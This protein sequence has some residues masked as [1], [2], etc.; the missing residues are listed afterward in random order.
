M[1]SESIEADNSPT[2]VA[3]HEAGH[4]IMAWLY[5]VPFESASID[6]DDPTFHGHVRG[7]A[8]LAPCPLDF[9]IRDTS[10]R[11]RIA[12][13]LMGESVILI[14]GVVAELHHAGHDPRGLI[15]PVTDDPHEDTALVRL[16]VRAIHAFTEQLDPDLRQQKRLQQVFQNIAFSVLAQRDIWPLV[17]EVAAL[18]LQR[19]TITKA[20]YFPLLEYHDSTPA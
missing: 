16:N 20:D 12:A 3:F 7:G 4:L 15:S 19:K 2:S 18:L 8:G 11:Q 13:G 6:S 14:A 10:E 5:R 17:Q 9:P 1:T